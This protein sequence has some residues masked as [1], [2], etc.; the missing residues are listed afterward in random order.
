MK[1]L[2]T[3]IQEGFHLFLVLC[4]QRLIHG[5]VAV[6]EDRDLRVLVKSRDDKMAHHDLQMLLGSLVGDELAILLLRLDALPGPSPP[7]SPAAAEERGREK[8]EREK[9]FM[10]IYDENKALKRSKHS[11][12]PARAARRAGASVLLLA[13][14][15]N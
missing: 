5:V 4:K 2:T 1:P 15:F 14:D 11:A 10:T 3:R 12:R 7:P 6:V 9:K 8:E 13:F